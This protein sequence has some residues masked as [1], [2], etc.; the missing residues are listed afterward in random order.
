MKK[1]AQGC[2]VIRFL[3][4]VSIRPL[5]SSLSSSICRRNSAAGAIVSITSPSRSTAPARP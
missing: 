2:G 4:V 5:H 1:L 3:F